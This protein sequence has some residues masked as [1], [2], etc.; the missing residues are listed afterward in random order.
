MPVNL[1]LKPCCIECEYVNLVQEDVI[2]SILSDNIR[3]INVECSHR[4]VCRIYEKDA[5]GPIATTYFERRY[6]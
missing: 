5:N 2:S 3:T 1:F 4:R 6:T